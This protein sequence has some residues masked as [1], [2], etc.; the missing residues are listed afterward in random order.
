MFETLLQTV[1]GALPALDWCG[2]WGGGYF[3]GPGY[4]MM[5][6]P[7]PFGIIGHGLFWIAVIALIVWAIVRLTRGR[8]AVPAEDPLDLLKRRLAAGEI[9]ADEFAKIKKTLQDKK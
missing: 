2:R 4:G 7:G 9:G 1:Y 5:G 8:R 6:W 3:G